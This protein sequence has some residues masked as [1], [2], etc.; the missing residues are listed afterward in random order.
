MTARKPAA[1]APAE[2]LQPLYEARITTELVIRLCADDSAEAERIVAHD[3]LWLGQTEESKKATKC[4]MW[5]RRDVDIG[6]VI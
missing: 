4:V 2:C 5:G 1:V 3:N 6:E